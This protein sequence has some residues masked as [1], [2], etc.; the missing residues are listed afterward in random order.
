MLRR[1][2]GGKNDYAI[3]QCIADAKQ[4]RG[5]GDDARRA[6]NRVCGAV[7]FVV[8]SLAVEVV[9]VFDCAGADAQK[10]EDQ[11]DGGKA[12]QD[13]TEYAGMMPAVNQFVA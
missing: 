4:R 10:C 9:P 5:G 12:T 1:Q 13:K 2:R 3:E 7:G 11:K 8:G 6:K